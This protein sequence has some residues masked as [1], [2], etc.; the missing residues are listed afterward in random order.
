VYTVNCDN[1]A[2]GY[3]P[4]VNF[5]SGYDATGTPNQQFLAGASTVND[6]QKHDVTLT[7]SGLNLGFVPNSIQI[8]VG[9]TSSP[10]AASDA[11]V[12]F[13]SA[14]ISWTC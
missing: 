9:Y 10:L 6:K 5:Y 3:R 12:S 7:V 11:K 1:G 13:E 14:S 4:Y 8:V 2:E